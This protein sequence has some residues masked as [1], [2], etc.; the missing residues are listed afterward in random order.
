MKNNLF[1]CLVVIASAFS[2]NRQEKTFQHNITAG[3]TPWTAEPS[4][5]IDPDFSFAIVSDLYSGEREG[6]FAVAVEQLNLLRPRFV[7]SIGDLIEGGTEDT[8][9]LKTEFDSFDSKIAKLNTPFFHVGGNHDLTNPVMRKF[10][11]QRYGKR[12]YHF[13]YNNV[14]FLMLDSED[15]NETRMKE[16]YEARAKAIVVLDGPNPE[17]AADM[18]YFKMPERK[19]G[20][21]SDEQSSYFEKVIKQNQNVRWTFILMHKPVW[22]REGDG[23]LSRIEGAL[24]EQNY[25]VINGHLHAYSYTHRN[26]RDYMILGTTSGGQNPQNDMAFDH[27]TLINMNEEKPGIVNLRLE[28]ILDKSGKIPLDGEK[29]CY[30]A[31]KCAP[32]K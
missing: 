8:V 9:V 26:N 15:Y 21:I 6:V 10:W 28:G 32:T 31:S 5:Q 2:C 20:E 7:L 14:L 27:V 30:Q 12:Y 4:A 13:L 29:Y 19:F 25:T 11:E 17:L 23:N 18:E 16:I 3:P 22:Q 1:I 24:G